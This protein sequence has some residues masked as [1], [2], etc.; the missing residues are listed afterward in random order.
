M[1]I[2]T[3]V[4]NTWKSQLEFDKDWR[5]AIVIGMCQYCCCCGC[6]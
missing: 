1:N 2:N 6:G 4:R 5:V 3:F